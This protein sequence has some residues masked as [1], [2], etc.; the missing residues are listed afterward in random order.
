MATQK[1]SAWPLALSM[2]ALIVYASLY[3]FSDWRNQGLE[4]WA[5]LWAPL[6]RYWTGFDVVSNLLGYAPLG[7]FLC[8]SG[9]R[10]GRARHALLWA[11]VACALLS[12]CMESLQSFLP[13][14]VASNLDL[15]LN[16]SGA[17]LGA[18]SALLLERMGALARWSRFRAHWF[19][20]DARGA[21]VLLS[22]W[23]FALLFPPAVPFGLGQVLERLEAAVGG[24]LQGTPFLDWLP[25]RTVELEPLVPMAEVLCVALGVLVP[26]LMGYSVIR[27]AWQ[28]ALFLIALI[29]IGMGA[30]GLSA[31]LS[32]GPAHAWGWLST[33]VEVGMVLATGLALASVLLP[34]RGCAALALLA[35]AV[36]LSVLNQAPTSAYFAQTLQT[37]EQGRFIRFHGLAQWLG[38]IWPYVALLYVLRR[39]SGREA[40]GAGP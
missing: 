37:W 9:L 19:V 36:A 5:F 21:L 11:S 20:R 32:Y 35:L 33:P 17:W 25:L 40:T 23:P 14:R 38:W 15:L 12:F 22:L 3:P 13:V 16:A 30:T 7:F 10:T 34:R 18:A 6:P 31:A 29:A 28:R 2:V 26:C 24:A 8:L 1:T 4:A 27:L 39:V